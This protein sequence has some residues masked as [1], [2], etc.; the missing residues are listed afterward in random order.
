MAT[1][2][3]TNIFLLIIISVLAGFFMRPLNMFVFGKVTSLGKYTNSKPLLILILIATMISVPGTTI[4]T[5]YFALKLFGFIPLGE[6]ATTFVAALIAGGVLWVLY[7][8]RFNAVCKVN[9]D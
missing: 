1:V 7:A 8:R 4:F 9:L 2:L 3:N 6:Y 5:I